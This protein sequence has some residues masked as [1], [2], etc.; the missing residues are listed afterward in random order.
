MSLGTLKLFR[1]ALLVVFTQ[2]LLANTVP[3]FELIKKGQQDGN[4]LLI[5]GGIQGDEPGGFMSASLIATHY[6]ITKGSVWVVPNLNFD[7]I[8]KRSRG[9]FGDMNRKFSNLSK[10]DP[11]FANVER[12][13]NLI[14]QDDVKM[15][16]NLHDGSGFY[17]KKYIDNMHSPRR[18]GQSV[19]ID[20]TKIKV[21][22]YNNLLEISNRITKSINKNLIKKEHYYEVRNTKTKDG[23]IEMEKSLTYFAINRG[24][25]AFAN[26]ASKSLPVHQRT[27]YHLLALEEYMAVM[28]IEFTRNFKL[29]SRALKNVID[30]DISISFHDNK[31]QLPLSK[32]RNIIKY[33][34]INK[35]GILKF[36][37][38]NP[39]MT[40]VK[41][42]N[43][44]AIHYGNRRVARLI[45]DYLEIDDINNF[46]E[47]KIDGIKK[48]VKL[49]TLLSVNKNFYIFPQDDVRVN[50]IGYS[51][52]NVKNE[53]GISVS[54]N[55]I[56]KKF[57]LDK[58][59]KIFRV[60]FYKEKKFA[61][62]LLVHFNKRKQKA[63]AFNNTN[64]RASLII[65]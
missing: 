61:G 60:E 41:K 11:D 34:P 5:I 6:T 13:K 46:V 29:Q 23:D 25:S 65:K 39:L 40:I 59:G 2:C 21:E 30:N 56:M 28:G 1:L 14:Q 18:W 62:M 8:I 54:K 15:I 32:I 12:I 20:Q 4:T 17:R 51:R 58:R 24:K 50:I 44:Y 31:V 19:I 42:D 7:S 27:Y 57:S 3:D 35:D 45:P 64:E 47:V 37:A 43:M 10:K 52:K 48:E 53:S 16:I 33:F 22:K 38:S 63:I 55:Q 9:R 49:G 36:K 26:E